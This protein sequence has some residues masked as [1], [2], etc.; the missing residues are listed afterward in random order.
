MWRPASPPPMMR[1]RSSPYAR[2]QR[3]IKDDDMMMVRKGVVVVKGD[4][5][6]LMKC[7]GF[8]F[9]LVVV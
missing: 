3:A 4:M 2:S 5:I 8:G 6:Q 7:F 9:A 1:V